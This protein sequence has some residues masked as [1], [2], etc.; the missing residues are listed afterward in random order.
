M[1]KRRKQGLAGQ[2]APGDMMMSTVI[3]LI[4]M[5]LSDPHPTAKVYSSVADCIVVPA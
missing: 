3:L 1:V 5:L 4:Q 2:S